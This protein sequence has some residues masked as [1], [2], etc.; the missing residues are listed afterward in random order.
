MQGRIDVRKT[1]G[2]ILGDGY[3]V[4]LDGTCLLTCFGP[5]AEARAEAEAKVRR[6]R[7]ANANPTAP[8]GPRLFNRR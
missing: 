7:L 5:Q 8:G 2:P 6:D 3:G 4:F 1:E